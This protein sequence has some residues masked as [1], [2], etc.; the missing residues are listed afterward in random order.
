MHNIKL[1]AMAET[2]PMTVDQT[3]RRMRDTTVKPHDLGDA[4]HMVR[5]LRHRRRSLN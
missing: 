4:L 3:I 1:E 5:L 2:L